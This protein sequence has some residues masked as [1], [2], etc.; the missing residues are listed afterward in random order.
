MAELERIEKLAAC[1]KENN[2]RL[3]VSDWQEPAAR[4]FIR[5]IQLQV[6]DKTITVPVFDEYSDTD[7]DNPILW[8]N[9][10]LDSC[11]G[12]EEAED[13]SVWLQDEG[14]KD[15]VFYQSLYQHYAEVIPLVRQYL[16]NEIKSIDCYHFE[17]NTD[18]AKALREY[19]L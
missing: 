14:Y 4:E 15:N 11:V 3:T 17:F 18:T 7:I 6:E 12:F 2:L 8:L 9:L 5:D 10:I 16:G 19:K 1:Y 13:Y